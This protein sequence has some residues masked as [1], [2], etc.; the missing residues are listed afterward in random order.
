VTLR[1]GWYWFGC[2]LCLLQGTE[3]VVNIKTCMSKP[4]TDAKDLTCPEQ[5][6]GARSNANDGQEW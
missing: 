2:R 5:H 1:L 6:C 3:M 4:T